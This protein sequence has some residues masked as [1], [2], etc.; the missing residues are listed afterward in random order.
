MLLKPCRSTRQPRHTLV[1]D[2]AERV[3]GDEV[4]TSTQGTA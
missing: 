1:T 4:I 2:L 3:A